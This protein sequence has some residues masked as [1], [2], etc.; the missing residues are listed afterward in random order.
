MG[1]HLEGKV[2]K[3]VFLDPLGLYILIYTTIPNFRFNSNSPDNH[4][5]IRFAFS[6]R[7]LLLYI[8]VLQS[9][10]FI[11]FFFCLRRN[12]VIVLRNTLKDLVG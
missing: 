7:V 12:A 6:R 1:S 4:D 8:F 10:F 3:I 2:D 11:I 9:Y 5:V